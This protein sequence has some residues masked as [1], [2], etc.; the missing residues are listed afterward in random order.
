MQVTVKSA[1]DPITAA[2]HGGTLIGC[3]PDYGHLAITRAEYEERGSANLRAH[4]ESLFAAFKH[5]ACLQ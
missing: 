1:H 4:L 2:W 3:S 5:V